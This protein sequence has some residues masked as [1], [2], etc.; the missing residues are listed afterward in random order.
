MVA[1]QHEPEPSIAARYIVSVKGRPFVMYAGLLDLAHQTGPF[2]IMTEV[3]QCPSDGNGWTAIFLCRVVFRHG[4]FTGIGDA[5][6]ENTSAMVSAHYI[7]IAET[8]AKARALRDALNIDMVAR[9]EIGDDDQPRDADPAP[10]RTS[11]VAMETPRR[12]EERPTPAQ[13]GYLKKLLAGKSHTVDV[14]TLSKQGASD[15]IA[16]LTAGKGGSA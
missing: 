11:R 7:R 4:T 1:P 14:A 2:D 13:L 15:L 16:E 3:V 5:N 12:D 9:E 6:P 8:R 10:A